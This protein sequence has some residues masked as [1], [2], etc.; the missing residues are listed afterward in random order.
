M[1]KKTCAEALGKVPSGIFVVTTKDGSKEAVLLA[2][3]VQQASFEP[4][5]LTMAVHRD[6]LINQMLKDNQPFAIHILGKDQKKLFQRFSKSIGPHE[7]PF[8]GLE[9]I[10]GST[11][12]PILKEAMAVIECRVKGRVPAGDHDLIIADIVDGSLSFDGDPRVH[13]RRNGLSY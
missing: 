5:K 6:R 10:Q 12:V 1:L 8:N 4:P 11:G 7:K 2:S 9:V 3:W 13:V